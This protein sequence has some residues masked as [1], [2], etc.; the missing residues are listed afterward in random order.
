MFHST[1]FEIAAFVAAVYLLSPLAVRW[2]YRFSGHWALR[3]V[4]LDALPSEVVDEFRKSIPELQELGFELIGCFDCGQLAEQTHS[5]LAYFCNR[6]SNDFANISAMTT[7]GRTDSYLEFSTSFKNGL[8]VE[9]NTNSVLPLTPANP[10]TKV[11]R[12]PKTADARTLLHTHHRLIDKYAAGLWAQAEPHGEEIKRYVRVIENY[13]PRHARIGYMFPAEDGVAYK[14]TWKG[15]FLITWRGLWPVSMVRR[16]MH[17]HFMQSEL[18][19]L[20]TRPVTALQK[21]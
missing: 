10:D 3:E 17:H 14:L 13:G 4:S 12:F 15:A 7:P 2:T 16:W 20:E 19:T 18:H 5:Y 6:L 9:T 21:A 8:T 11:F 1:A